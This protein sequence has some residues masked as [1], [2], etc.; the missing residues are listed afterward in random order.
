MTTTTNIS[1]AVGSAVT[2]AVGSAVTDAVVNATLDRTMDLLP[3][4]R[5]S[6]L[7]FFGYLQSFVY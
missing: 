3:N 6:G 7:H 5:T 1:D 2:D 4:N